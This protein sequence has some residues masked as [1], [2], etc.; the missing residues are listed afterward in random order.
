MEAGLSALERPRAVREEN[1][2][3]RHRY[4]VLRCSS[5]LTD[6]GRPE[7]RCSTDQSGRSHRGGHLRETLGKKS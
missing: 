3:N 6:Q 4:L 1:I 7:S 2:S 5:T